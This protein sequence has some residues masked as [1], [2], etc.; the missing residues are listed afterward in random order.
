MKLKLLSLLTAII[1]SVPAVRA[2][3]HLGINL[4]IGVPPP[5]VVRRAPPRPIVETTV[6][7]PAPE[8]VLVPGH[9]SWVE[10]RWLWV[11]SAWVLPPQPGA[12]WVAGRWEKRTRNWVEGHWEIV[13]PA[14]VMAPPPLVPGGTEIYVEGAPPPPQSEIVVAAPAPDYVWVTGFWSWNAGR[15][16]WVA[17]RWERPPHGLHAWVAPRWERRGHGYVLVRGFWR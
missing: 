6:A 14:V 2:E 7:C 11:R 12:V 13:Q 17:G 3:T 4:N 10:G 5:I 8:Y 9:Y 16:V 1:A 15:H